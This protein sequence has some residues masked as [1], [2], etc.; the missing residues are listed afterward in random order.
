MTR[1]KEKILLKDQKSKF[2]MAGSIEE[3][4]KR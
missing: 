3:V 1:I 2:N 4:L